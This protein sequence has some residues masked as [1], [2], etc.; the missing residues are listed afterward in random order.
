MLF[1]NPKYMYPRKEPAR[2]GQALQ[3][4]SF[5]VFVCVR[6]TLLKVDLK[7]TKGKPVMWSEPMKDTQGRIN[8]EP[9]T[10][11]F[12]KKRTKALRW[13]LIG[14]RSRAVVGRMLPALAARQDGIPISAGANVQHQSW[15][16]RVTQN[17]FV[18]KW[19]PV[20]LSLVSC[21]SRTSFLDG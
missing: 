4:C 15:R 12:R 13:Q 10:L 11:G 3:T 9:A 18:S 16:S 17:R 1:T 6:G 19:D 8:N 20:R 14:S 7:R 21:Q 2:S 5:W